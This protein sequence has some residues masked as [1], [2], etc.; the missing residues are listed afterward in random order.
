MILKS[1]VMSGFPSLADTSLKDS[2]KTHISHNTLTDAFCHWTMLVGDHHQLFQIQSNLISYRIFLPSS[3]LSTPFHPMY[4]KHTYDVQEQV[5]YFTLLPLSFT[6]HLHTG[7]YIILPRI[8]PEGEGKGLYAFPVPC[9]VLRDF[10]L[11]SYAPF[12]AI[13]DALVSLASKNASD[14][15]TITA[16]LKGLSTM[17]KDRP[18]VNRTQSVISYWSHQLRLL[19]SPLEKDSKIRCNVISGAR[20]SGKSKFGMASPHTLIERP[21]LSDS[22]IMETVKDLAPV[23]GHHEITGDPHALVAACYESLLYMIRSGRAIGV[24]VDLINDFSPGSLLASLYLITDTEMPTIGHPQPSYE[25]LASS[26]ASTG[27]QGDE[28]EY[29]SRLQDAQSALGVDPSPMLPLLVFADEVSSSTASTLF[30]IAS[31]QMSYRTTIFSFGGYKQDSM[32]ASM[33]SSNLTAR[34]FKMEALIETRHLIEFLLTTPGYDSKMHTVSRKGIQ[35]MF[36]SGGNPR[37]LSFLVDRY[38]DTTEWMSKRA[39][40]NYLRQ[41]KKELSIPNSALLTILSLCGLPLR[42]DDRFDFP[43]TRN[44]AVN[45]LDYSKNI[46]T[47]LYFQP[48]RSTQCGHD[49]NNP[50]EFYQ[51]VVP[52]RIPHIGDNTGP[53]AVALA[54]KVCACIDSLI[55]SSD[56]TRTGLSLESAVALF[57]S[58]RVFGY[59]RILH[60]SDTQPLMTVERLLGPSL[61]QHQHYRPGVI[62]HDHTVSDLLQ[63][64]RFRVSHDLSLF[65]PLPKGV[66]KE[67]NPC[68]IRHLTQPFYHGS[69]G[70]LLMPQ[71]AALKGVMP[72]I[73]YGWNLNV[74]GLEACDIVFCGIDAQGNDFII[75]VDLKKHCTS[76]PVF[77]KQYAKCASTLPAPRLIVS[78][79][80]TLS[81]EDG[82]SGITQPMMEISP[83]ELSEL[84]QTSV[85]SLRCGWSVSVDIPHIL[86]TR[87]SLGQVLRAAVD[88]A[89]YARGMRQRFACSFNGPQTAEMWKLMFVC[90]VHDMFCEWKDVVVYLRSKITSRKK[91]YELERFIRNNNTRCKTVFDKYRDQYLLTPKTVFKALEREGLT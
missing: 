48:E 60:E 69:P 78:L 42:C 7:D 34:S 81:A 27:D 47:S 55:Q 89:D 59:R 63:S 57:F 56:D 26:I 14:A 82:R 85:D 15:T 41:E 18:L 2:S 25:H 17:A 51:V 6:T 86:L 68:T 16:R 79:R 40:T 87:E 54:T 44:I 88:T 75:V 31:I 5:D 35:T 61:L 36:Y 49:P 67:V 12:R 32:L 73:N 13:E 28:M 90:L 21:E 3:C 58:G 45:Q 19:I 33:D 77:Y 30:G 10:R 84:R 38:I 4:I 72:D 66:S 22:I 39:L 70:P 20:G 65:E 64:I 43:F 83:E 9:R 23:L 29:L 8:T 80:A 46:I 50:T 53:E 52:V 24:S 1:I 37:V 74:E 71:E 62:S 91:R 76:L 11:T